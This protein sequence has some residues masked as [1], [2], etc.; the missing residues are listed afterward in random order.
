MHLTFE[1]RTVGKDAA[2]R[3]LGKTVRS[4]AAPSAALDVSTNYEHVVSN[5]IYER[6]LSHR[7]CVRVLSDVSSG[8][9]AE[10][11]SRCYER[12]AIRLRP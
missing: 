9:A 2:T 10:S 12:P 6:L 5:V 7:K 8:R 4:V 1:Y 3:L 11:L